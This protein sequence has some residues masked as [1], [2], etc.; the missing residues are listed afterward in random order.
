MEKMPEILAVLNNRLAELN[1]NPEMS[2][3][4]PMVLC[5]FAP[6]EPNNNL[7]RFPV[8]GINLAM[9]RPIHVENGSFG[10]LCKI[11]FAKPKGDPDTIT[12]II[13]Y[14]E[15]LKEAHDAVTEIAPSADLEPQNPSNGYRTM[16]KCNEKATQNAFKLL[17][18]KKKDFPSLRSIRRQLYLV[19]IC[20]ALTQ[21]QMC[22]R[23]Y[24]QELG[25]TSGTAN[26]YHHEVIYFWLRVYEQMNPHMPPY[27][28]H[29]LCFYLPESLHRKIRKTI[30]FVFS[31]L[32][33]GAFTNEGYGQA[34]AAA[35]YNPT[36]RFPLGLFT[37]LDSRYFRELFVSAY[38]TRTPCDIDTFFVPKQRQ[39]ILSQIEQLEKSPE[40]QFLYKVTGEAVESAWDLRKVIKSNKFGKKENSVRVRILKHKTA[41]QDGTVLFHC[42]GGW[43][44]TLLNFILFF[45]F[46]FFTF[47]TSLIESHLNFG[48]LNFLCFYFFSYRRLHHA[49]AGLSRGEKEVSCRCFAQ[50]I[51]NS[52]TVRF[53]EL[54]FARQIRLFHTKP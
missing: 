17:C 19:K 41:K 26:V 43:W 37:K 25:V 36:M 20:L 32:A 39:W 7:L 23:D 8:K 38:H 14:L 21:L 46:F 28:V 6:Y 27:Y 12:Q 51:H 40:V 33:G 1:A 11:Y 50:N 24:S 45:F 10:R 9:L 54:A 13:T 49:L 18:L 31:T 30:R 4:K 42:H 3:V 2:P 5:G 15:Q 34:A 52:I 48:C 44:Q 16:L 29:H 22:F 47:P 35:M 53:D